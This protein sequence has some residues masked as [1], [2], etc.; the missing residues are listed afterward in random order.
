[1]C[2]C[3]REYMVQ[4][5]GL[6]VCRRCGVA[7]SEP[8]YILAPLHTCCPARPPYSRRKRYVRLLHNVWAARTSRCSES[9]LRAL[10]TAN[11]QSSKDIHDFIRQSN[12]R[13]F[14]R[15]DCLAALSAQLLGHTI[16]PL[17]KSEICWATSCF[18]QIESLHLRR[19]GVFPAYSFIIEMCLRHTKPQRADL[20]PY[21][22]VL[23]CA[24]RRAQYTNIYGHIFTR[25]A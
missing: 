6:H 24:K 15:Y 13:E 23:K 1:M 22:H 25:L 4:V 21:V 12:T 8:I 19:G 18:E 3:K 10:V 11:P 20:L 5:A 2:E 14:K 17:G 7:K 9:F 16:Q